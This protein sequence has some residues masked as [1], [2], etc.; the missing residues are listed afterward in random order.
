MSFGQVAALA[1]VPGSMLPGNI[2]DMISVDNNNILFLI[3]NF[4]SVNISCACAI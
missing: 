4:L 3:K 1:T 2:Q